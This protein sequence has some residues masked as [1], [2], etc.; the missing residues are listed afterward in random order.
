VY[1]N[2][3]CPFQYFSSH[4]LETVDIK[5]E[6]EDPNAT[7]LYQRMLKDFLTQLTRLAGKE[8]VVQDFQQQEHLITQWMALAEALRKQQLMRQKKIERAREMVKEGGEFS[9]MSSFSPLTFPLDPSMKVTGVKSDDLYFFKSKLEP[10]RISMTTSSNHMYQLLFKIGDDL[11]QDQLM[12]QMISLMDRLLKRENLDLKLTPYKVLATS[13]SIGMLECVQN[14]KNI[15]DIVKDYNKDSLSLQK[16]LAKHN[17]DPSG[18][19]GV[20]SQALNNFVRSCAGYCVIT[21][22]LG[23]GDRHLDNILMTYDGR[24]FHIDFGFVLGRD[25]KPFAPPFKLSP[26]MV[27][28]MGGNNSPHYHEFKTYCCEAFNILRKHASLILNMFSLMKDASIPDINQGEKSVLKVKEKLVLEKTDE[29]ASRDFQTLINDTARSVM[30]VLN[31]F[32]HDWG[33]YWRD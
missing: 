28:C 11:R 10:M 5:V 8:Q 13:R 31:D 4:A 27:A 14:S 9:W 3:D 26:Q 20:K 29:Q 2:F 15:N 17:P 6:T 22:I 18:P 32:F 24:M 30:P 19:Y 23:I 33:N 25:P 12:V 21:F 16:F 1:E 7:E